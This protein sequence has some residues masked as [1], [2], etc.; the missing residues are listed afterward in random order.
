MAKWEMRAE[1]GDHSISASAIK[2]QSLILYG[3]NHG[4]PGRILNTEMTR[5]E[6]YFN[7]IILKCSISHIIIITTFNLPTAAP[8]LQ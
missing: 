7:R 1:F 4:K 2:L 5:S 8:R 6:F 3:D